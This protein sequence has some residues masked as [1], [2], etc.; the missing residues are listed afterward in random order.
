MEDQKPTIVILVETHLGKKEEVAI[1]GYET[2]YGND[3]TANRGGIIVETIEIETMQTHKQE[4]VGERLCI[5][6][7]NKNTK[8]KLGVIYAPQE[9]TTPN[10]E[11]RKMYQKIKDQI[12]QARQ[13]CQIIIIL[14][15]F[16][17]KIRARIKRKQRASDK[18]GETNYKT[19]R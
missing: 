19:S 2:I 10:K 5:L 12:E 16:N 9:N 1:P 11:L 7:D 17:A 8:L 18:R 13:Q 14:R 3:K 6:I 4:Q 15:D